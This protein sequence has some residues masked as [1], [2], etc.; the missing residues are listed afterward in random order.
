MDRV[1]ARGR[2]RRVLTAVAAFI[3]LTGLYLLVLHIFRVSEL[4]V[5]RRFGAVS[6][7]VAAGEVYLEPLSIDA[8]DDAMRMR[9]Y[10]APAPSGGDTV[11]NASSRDL[12]LLVSHDGTVEQLKL[13]AGEHQ[14]AATFDVDLNEG[15]VAR[16][17]LDAYVARLGVRLLDGNSRQKLPVGVTIWEGALGYEL[18][19]TGQPGPSP[20]DV[21]LLTAV[22]RSGAT[23]LFALCIYGAMLGLSVSA[24]AVGFLTFTNVCRPEATLIGALASICFVLPVL[25]NALPGSPPHGVD[26][27]MW[28][29]LWSQ[30]LT[31][32][33]LVLLVYK[34]ATAGH[35]SKHA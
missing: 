3:A 1:Q 18:H 6:P 20:E 10:L 31:V 29:F 26:A 19:T 16:Y 35:P 5:E 8:L 4:P 2:L 21:H 27:D 33:C 12:T 30:L 9:A 23:A 24:L 13:A 25:R 14:A 7:G 17:P 34:W 32:A 15:S 11:P 22:K 28:V